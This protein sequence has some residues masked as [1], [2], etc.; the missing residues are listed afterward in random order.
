LNARR[1]S[2]LATN[3]H[4]TPWSRASTASREPCPNLSQLGSSKPGPVGGSRSPAAPGYQRPRPIRRG[5][6]RRSRLT[7]FVAPTPN[8][9]RL[10]PVEIHRFN[11]L[12]QDLT[13]DRQGAPRVWRV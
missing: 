1:V 3:T 13:V 8:S 6:P 10:P 12:Y 5:P 2:F 11:S 9:S 4:A 7:G